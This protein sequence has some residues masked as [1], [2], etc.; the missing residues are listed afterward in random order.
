MNRFLE[1]GMK[2]FFKPTLRPL[3]F[4]MPHLMLK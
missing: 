3:E 1:V 2:A 4:G